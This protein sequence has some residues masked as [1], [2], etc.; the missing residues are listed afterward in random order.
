MQK[1][2]THLISRHG[3]MEPT[4]VHRLAAFIMTFSAK[5]NDW[6]HGISSSPFFYHPI[7]GVFSHRK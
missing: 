4:F 7:G 1:K 2:G 5:C 6:N 3:G